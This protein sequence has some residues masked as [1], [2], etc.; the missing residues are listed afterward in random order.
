MNN[1]ASCYC[2]VFTVLLVMVCT[3]LSSIILYHTVY[4]I[5]TLAVGTYE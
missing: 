2:T 5:V 4:N 3:A 1:D